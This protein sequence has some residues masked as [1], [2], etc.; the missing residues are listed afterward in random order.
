MASP[1]PD[2][3][4]HRARFEAFRT[5]RDTRYRS[6]EGWLTFVDRIGLE[7]GENRLP[8]GILVVAADGQVRLRRPR[9]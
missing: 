7:T 2:L 4:A 9:A 5:R 8:I 3:E 1:D 6:E